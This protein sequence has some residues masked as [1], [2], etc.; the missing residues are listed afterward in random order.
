MF[1]D[2]GKP[3]CAA[4]RSDR[5]TGVPSLMNRRLPSPIV[6]AG[7][8][9]HARRALK[10]EQVIGQRGDLLIPRKPLPSVGDFRLRRDHFS[11]QD[12]IENGGV[13]AASLIMG[14]F[15]QYH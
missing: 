15:P 1:V 13:L 4:D 10:D 7:K 8:V 3:Q 11:D 2:I 5:Y 9:L 6:L 14:G 12:R